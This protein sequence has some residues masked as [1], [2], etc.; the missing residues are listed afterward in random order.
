[1]RKSCRGLH[2]VYSK[3]F[4]NG[5]IGDPDKSPA[6][7]WKA[8]DAAISSVK[9]ETTRTTCEIASAVQQ[10]EFWS[11]LVSLRKLPCLLLKHTIPRTSLCG[12]KRN[13]SWNLPSREQRKSILSLPVRRWPTTVGR[14]WKA[15]KNGGNTGRGEDRWGWRTFSSPMI[16]RSP[17]QKSSRRSRRTANRRCSILPTFEIYIVDDHSLRVFAAS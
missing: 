11:E 15:W 8:L 4:A 6:D 12:M 17:R 5:L 3:R 7:M 9:D 2:T 10:V 14:L 16:T 1:M 13:L